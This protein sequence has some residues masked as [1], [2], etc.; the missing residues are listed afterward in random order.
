LQRLK[1][2]PSLLNPLDL[3]EVANYKTGIAIAE[4]INALTF[5]GMGDKINE[6]GDI[7]NI[8][9]RLFSLALLLSLF[10]L[11]S[12]Q[13]MTSLGGSQS[14]DSESSESGGREKGGD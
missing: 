9:K 12:C 8:A 5:L 3:D 1:P 14:S 6:W 10:A 7:M 11:A 4:P 2:N 13:S